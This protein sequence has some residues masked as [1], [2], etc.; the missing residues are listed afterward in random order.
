VG[1]RCQ[2]QVLE[3]LPLDFYSGAAGLSGRFSEELSIRRLQTS[4]VDFVFEHLSERLEGEIGE[5]PA[6]SPLGIF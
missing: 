1:G 3:N 2:G 6:Q 4:P 5:Q